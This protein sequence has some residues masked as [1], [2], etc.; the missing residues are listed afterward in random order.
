MSQ[1][2]SSEKILRRWIS[3]RAKVEDLT[4]RLHSSQESLKTLE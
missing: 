3:L 1:E 4:S 2:K